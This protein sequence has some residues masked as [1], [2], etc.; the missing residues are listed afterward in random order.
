MTIFS[1]VL[2]PHKMVALYQEQIDMMRKIYQVPSEVVQELHKQMSAKHYYGF[3]ITRSA[4][5]DVRDNLFN[6]R[7]SH[8]S[9][10]EGQMLA[11]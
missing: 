4:D 3:R 5:D 8:P 7:Q 1:S 9:N 6:L 10:D 11:I 2:P